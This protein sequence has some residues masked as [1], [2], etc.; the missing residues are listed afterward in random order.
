[1]NQVSVPLLME[2][3][4][5]GRKGVQLPACSVPTTPLPDSLLRTD[6][7]LPEV[8]ELTVVRHFTRLSQRNYSIDTQFYPLG[9]C[10]MKYNPK[11]NEEAALYTGFRR[12]HPLA[13]EQ[14][15][16]GALCLMYKLQEAL[17]AITGFSGVSLQPAAGAQAEYAGLCVI[18]S[19]HNTKGEPWRKRILIP[20]SAHG[21]NPASCTMAGFTTESL[22]STASGDID[23][24]ALKTIC[25][26]DT[27]HT[28]AGIMITN[29][30]TL[31]LF[32]RNIEQI[33]HYVHEAGGMVYGD[34]ANMNALI[35]IVKPA[36]LGFDLMHLNLHK[37]FSTPHGGG[38]PGAGALCCSSELAQFLPGPVVTQKGEGYTF[39]TP[40]ASIGKLKAFYGNFGVL[41][42]AYA[43]IKRLGAAGLR[44]VAEYSV[45]NANYLRMLIK[46]DLPV[47]YGNERWNMHEFVVSPSI[48]ND[49]RTV[50]IAKRLIDYGFHPPTIYF[51]LIVK[52]ALMIEP[53]ETEGP[54]TLEAFARAI[55]AIF[56]EIKT[57]PG[58]VKSAPHTMVVSRLDEVTAARNPILRYRG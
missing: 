26:S 23:L 38:G 24:D 29:P 36:D 7:K 41:V 12:C 39:Y 57:N 19:Y 21:T 47:V 17:A 31:G 5:P 52:E 15:V 14:Q 46:D 8:D 53:T 42:R 18:R 35:G 13:P 55:H 40:V 30:N 27:E 49:I 37:T 32:E 43:Y 22:P 2:M 1:M 33:T 58:I 44:R 54:E 45:L 3:S 56:E 51:P 16:Q 4:V 34:G 20:D 48:E 11:M 10:T 28:L 25:S 6:L 50:D 9:S